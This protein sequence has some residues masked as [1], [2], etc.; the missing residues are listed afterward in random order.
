[1]YG[2]QSNHKALIQRRKRLRVKEDV[3]TEAQD[4][5]TEAETLLAV[6]L[7]DWRTRPRAECRRLQKQERP[8]GFSLSLQ[9]EPAPLAPCC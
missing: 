8:E 2:A 9:E 4:R 1:M 6:R 7:E 5:Q 3:S